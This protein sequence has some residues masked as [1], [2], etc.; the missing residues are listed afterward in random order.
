MVGLIFLFVGIGGERMAQAGSAFVKILADDSQARRT[1]NGFFG[2]L[3][4]T[5]SIAAGVMG[6]LAVFETVKNTFE[7][8]SKSTIGANADMETYYNTLKVVLKSGEEA[9]KTLDWA[10]K[11]AVTTPF[12]I[13][14]IVEATT[15]L[16]SYGMVAQDTLGDIGDMASV[17]G[18]PLMQAVN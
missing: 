10:G 3:K 4:K 16:A 2:F 9:Q 13:P 1:I 18:K 12:E 15:R 14:E 17:M 6:G 11:F 8:L 7:G 5:G